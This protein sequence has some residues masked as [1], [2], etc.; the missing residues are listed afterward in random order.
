MKDYRKASNKR[1]LLQEGFIGEILQTPKNCRL[2][3]KT[4]GKRKT[5]NVFIIYLNCILYMM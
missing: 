2:S 3:A 4:K 1:P 5:F